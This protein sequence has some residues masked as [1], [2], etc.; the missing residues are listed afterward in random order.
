MALKP[1]VNTH[2]QFEL[3]RSVEQCLWIMEHILNAMPH[4]FTLHI[5]Y[6][7]SNL[8]KRTPI[9]RIYGN[10][11]WYHGKRRFII[12]AN[13]IITKLSP[14]IKNDSPHLSPSTPY[15]PCVCRVQILGIGCKA[16]EAT[17]TKLERFYGS[18]SDISE[19]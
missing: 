19:E 1:C 3:C 6:T 10:L 14:N 15:S 9:P 12:P 11:S 16:D 18:Y 13:L 4:S 8:C 5:T 7:N 2:G 17:K